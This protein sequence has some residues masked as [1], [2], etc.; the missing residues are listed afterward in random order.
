MPARRSAAVTAAAAALLL[1]AAPAQATGGPAEGGTGE[2]RASA[3]VLRTGLDVSLLDK[4]AGVPLNLSLNEV[5]APASAGKTALT[6]KLDGVDHGTPFNVLRAEVATAR[7][8]ADKHKAEGYVNLVRAQVHV[9]GLPLLGLIKLRAV[10]SEATC[11]AGKR[12]TAASNLLGDVVV[13]GKKVTV[14][15]G[16]PTN[17]TVPGVGE[18]RL[19]LSKAETTSRTAAATALE[20]DVRVKPLNLNVAEV[21]GRMTLAKASCESPKG[22][23]TS[24][25]AG[26]PSGA[27]SSEPASGSAGAPADGAPTPTAAKADGEAD[28]KDGTGTGTRTGTGAAA[29]GLA[30]TGADSSTPFLAAGAGALVVVGAGVLYAARRR[31]AAAEDARA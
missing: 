26:D 12:P 10:T 13:L 8:T 4:T 14:T 16:G 23:G 19:H 18:V 17:V 2:G 1:A 24:S 30:E 28:T 15:A 7:A 5:Q 22:G 6:A 25:S 11:E 27:P 21:A 3:A 20:L 9:P 31:K 29:Q